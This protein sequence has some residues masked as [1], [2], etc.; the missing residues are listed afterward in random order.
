MISAPD[1]ILIAPILIP[2][3]AGALMLFY[4]GSQQRVIAVASAIAQFVVAVELVDMAT[5]DATSVGLYLLGDWPPP[6]AI[7]LVLDR[8]SALMVMLTSILALPAIVFAMARWDRR[9]QHFHSLFQFLLMGLNGAFL[10]GDL[11]NL[12]VFFEVLLAASYGLALHGSGTLRVR[13]GLHY[14]AI[15]LAASLLFLIGVS[16]IYGVTGTLNMADLAVRVPLVAAENRPL[17]AAG[18]AVLGIAFLVKAAMW[19]FCFW[20]PLTY[21]AAAPPAAAIFAVLS[22]V[23]IYVVLR[24]S[25]LAFG[26]AA[27]QMT[28]LGGEVLVVGGIATLV[29]GTIG[30]LASQGLGRLAGCSVL[31]SS[32]TLLAVVGISSLG[33]GS[34]MVAAALYYL[35]ASTIASSA[36]FLMVE[37]IE[38][39][40]G[41]LAGILTVTAEAYGLGDDQMEEEVRLGSGPGVTGATTVLG[42]CF[43]TCALVLAGMPPLA[44]F[45]GKFAMLSAVLSFN[46]LAD[47]EWPG[48][49]L[50]FTAVVILSGLAALIALVREGVRTF[51]AAEEEELPSVPLIELAPVIV[52]LALTFGMTVKAGPVMR[53]MEATATALHH[54]HVYVRGVLGSQGTR[55]PATSETEAAGP[56]ETVRDS[57]A[58]EVGN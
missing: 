56:A 46:S 55:P 31:V 50:A 25:S 44:G 6:F 37:L 32:G 47:R 35:V 21:M 4:G 24:V 27:T 23:G 16:L 17:L 10:T 58:P 40:H 13:A 30:V 45:L 38:R 7:V 33:G 26:S 14:I 1:H 20:L 54:P 41:E 18:V 19:P 36:L 12:F 52:L 48:L 5:R 51:W 15:N 43:L 57:L 42:L 49:G 9:G 39:E 2:L 3:I 29:Y 11:F 28:G 53:Y 34:T 22:K 8:L